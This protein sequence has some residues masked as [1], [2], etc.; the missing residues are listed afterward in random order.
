MERGAAPGAAGRGAAPAGAG[1]SG[2]GGRRAAAA[3]QFTTLEQYAKASG[4]DR[5]SVLV[6]YDVFV[7]VPK[8][9]RDP[10]TVQ[11]LYNF[12]DFD[13]RLRPG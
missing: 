11:R 3:H 1:A 12:S 7:N 5:N 13:F 6:D 8:L 2:W 4:Q 9:E 10:K